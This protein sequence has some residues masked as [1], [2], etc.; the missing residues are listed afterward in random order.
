MMFSKKG[1]HTCTWWGGRGG[2]PQTSLWYSSST[3]GSIDAYIK[4]DML[5]SNNT[6]KMR[7]IQ[8]GGTMNFSK[9]SRHIGTWGRGRGGSPIKI[10][11]YVTK[12]KDTIRKIIKLKIM[13]V[14]LLT[15]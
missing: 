9:K 8:H 6:K 2:S 15:E 4:L 5:M 10:S 14:E 7:H 3:N 13:N 11:C 1:K 12:H